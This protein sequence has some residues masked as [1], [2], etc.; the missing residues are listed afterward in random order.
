MDFLGQAIQL[1]ATLLLCALPF[2]IIT[3]ALAGRPAVSTLML[4][5]GLNQQAA[6]DFNHLFNSSAAT[7][8]AVTGLSWV[9]FIL[10]GLASAGSIQRLYQR[11]FQL[12]GQARDPL[13]ALVW[14]AVLVGWA[15]LGTSAGPGI[16]AGAPVLWWII[17]VPAFMAFWWFTMWFLLGGR[18]PGR[19]LVPC[20]VA[21]STF[22]I[23]MLV[24]FH[25]TFSDMII[26][27][28]QKYGPI[29]VVLA[30]MSF[31]IAIGVVI[32]LGAVTGMMWRDRG[33]SF[34]A[35]VTRARR[36]S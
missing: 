5:L 29:G 32:T 16:H 34:R 14:L 7:S 19:R 13:R 10:G 8:S 1:A 36:S 18:I 9:F 24:V 30:L 33:L 15:A 31:F 26:S 6:A 4:R 25:F 35:A 28:D 3:S 22:W 2:M 11:V 12:R 20:A 17:N 23:G 21:T 27:Y